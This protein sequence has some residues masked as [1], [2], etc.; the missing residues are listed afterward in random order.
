MALTVQGTGGPDCKVV[1]KVAAVR[2][3]CDP[4][5][6]Q[7][8]ILKRIPDFDRA[9][10]P[11]VDKA[12]DS[13]WFLVVSLPSGRKDTLTVE[14]ARLR[15]VN[16]FD[17]VEQFR[18]IKGYKIDVLLV[19]CSPSPQL[20]ISIPLVCV[21]DAFHCYKTH[22]VVVMPEMCEEPL[23]GL[24]IN[25]Q[26]VNLEE[27]EKKLVSL[28][29]ISE[30]GSRG[31]IIEISRKKRRVTVIDVSKKSPLLLRQECQ[32]G[33]SRE[34]VVTC[35]FQTSICAPGGYMEFEVWANSIVPRLSLATVRLIDDQSCL[36]QLITSEKVVFSF[37]LSACGTR[38]VVQGAVVHYE[39]EVFSKSEL[40]LGTILRNSEYRLLVVCEHHPEDTIAVG[41][42]VNTSMPMLPVLQEGPL[43]LLLRVFHDGAFNMPYGQQEH[44]VFRVLREPIHLQL[45]LNGRSDPTLELFLDDCWATSNA[46]PLSQPQWIVV[47]DGCANGGD[48]YPTI[49]HSVTSEVGLL[50][51]PSRTKRF[52][53]KAFIFTDASG[54]PS[55]SLVYFH[56]SAVVCDLSRPDVEQCKPSC[57]GAASPSR[58]MRRS[59]RAR[60]ASMD[61]LRGTASLKEPVIVMVTELQQGVLFAERIAQVTD[62]QS[63]C[64]RVANPSK[65]EVCFECA[66]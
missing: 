46:D 48:D 4:R 16:L 32:V 37:P 13:S 45:E 62:G 18:N 24:T 58:M 30:N 39:N 17:T 49:F 35:A 19:H 9:P 6:L 1:G 8:T 61:D 29:K 21:L 31:Y 15:G 2:F 42:L 43:N 14:Q 53:V 60:R 66:G 64:A 40:V 33:T 54:V 12:Y 34:Y 65:C 26:D 11:N 5:F 63:T 23:E 55:Q 52:D 10:R 47:A 51:P 22:L 59:L 20:S 28:Q 38:K 3:Q 50:N 27:L 41:F 56:C 57:V 36:P 7:A 25:G 44:P